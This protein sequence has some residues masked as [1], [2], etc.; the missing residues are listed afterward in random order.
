VTRPVTA[1]AALGFVIVG[2]GCVVAGGL[3]SAATAH[4]PSEHATWAAAYLV[5]V[6]GVAQI[7]LGIGQ[8]HLSDTPPSRR[9]LTAEL[10]GWNVGNAAVILGTVTGA[11]AVTDV[12]GALLVVAFG[13]LLSGVRSGPAPRV[14]LW[15]YRSLLVILLLSIP[16]GLILAEVRPH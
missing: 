10:V 9:R 7:V 13:L 16:V 6:A 2:G 12:G 5:L 14:A 15:V 4:G 3:L 11:T 1:P 8:A